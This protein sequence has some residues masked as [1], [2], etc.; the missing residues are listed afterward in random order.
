[1]I[2]TLTHRL[3]HISNLND[4]IVLLELA[5]NGDDAEVGLV[6]P[7]APTL[8]LVG[9]VQARRLEEAPLATFGAVEDGQGLGVEPL[10]A[11]GLLGPLADLD[12]LAEDL[13]LEGE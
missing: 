5:H 8:A 6:L 12:L 2:V 1:M 11:V 9:R 4:G 10:V 3:I 7:H 13:K